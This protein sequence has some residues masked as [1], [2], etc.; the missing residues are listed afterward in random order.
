[1]RENN[2]QLVFTPGYGFRQLLSSDFYSIYHAM[3]YA[4]D[5]AKRENKLCYVSDCNDGYLVSFN[6]SDNWLFRAYPGG[7]KELSMKGKNVI[8]SKQS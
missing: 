5:A 2:I 8:D 1:M 6:W 3:K 7:R 4:I